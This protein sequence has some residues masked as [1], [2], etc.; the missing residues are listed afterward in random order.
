[1]SEQAK[2]PK[3]YGNYR[4]EYV[5][6]P[7]TKAILR[8]SGPWQIVTSARFD[9][10]IYDESDRYL[11]T[12]SRQCE[13]MAPFGCWSV[14]RF[15]YKGKKYSSLVDSIFGFLTVRMRAKP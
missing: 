3:V 4:G 11:E 6:I 15:S 1:M 12:V 13:P 7:V 14:W 9:V 10:V 2:I 5:N 8:H